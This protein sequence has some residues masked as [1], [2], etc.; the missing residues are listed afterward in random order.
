MVG[1]QKPVP[2]YLHTHAAPLIHGGKAGPAGYQTFKTFT[3]LVQVLIMLPAQPGDAAL[4]LAVELRTGWLYAYVAYASTFSFRECKHVYVSYTVLICKRSARIAG[5]RALGNRNTCHGDCRT[6]QLRSI[7]C[8]HAQ[9]LY[10]W[11]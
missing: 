11:Q 7:S 5:W 4:A 2:P 10:Q 8:R 1:R 9:R 3:R 6:W